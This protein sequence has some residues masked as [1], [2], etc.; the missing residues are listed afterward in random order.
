MAT[1]LVNPISGI[2]PSQLNGGQSG[3]APAYAIRAWVSFNGTGAVTIRG[4]GN[5]SSITDNGIGD[6]TVNMTTALPDANYAVVGS[7]GG[8]SATSQGAVYLYE[9]START[10][11]LFRVLTLNTA[12]APIDTPY[13]DVMV[14]R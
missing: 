12:F 9:Q 8:A 3:S 11:S 5:V 1:D 6:Y 2:T 13:I 4:S 14:I 10:T 7:S